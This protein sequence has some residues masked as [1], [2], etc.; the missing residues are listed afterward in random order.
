M[1][2]RLHHRVTLQEISRTE[3]EG[4]AY[5]T[6]WTT[7]SVIWANVQ[8]KNDQSGYFETYENQKEQ[9]ITKYEITLRA[10]NTITNKNRFLFENNIFVIESTAD[11]INRGRMMKVRC[12]LENT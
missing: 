8:A 6:S 10:G 7:S 11:V 12:R 9:Q 2:T 5:T 4:G 3:F 1:L